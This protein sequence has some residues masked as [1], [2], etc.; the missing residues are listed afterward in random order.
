[1]SEDLEE[2]DGDDRVNFKWA[3]YDIVNYI[4]PNYNSNKSSTVSY[5]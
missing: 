1:M 2:E 3:K 5:R 4:I